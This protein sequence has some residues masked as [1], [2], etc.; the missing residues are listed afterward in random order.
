LFI[1]YLSVLKRR[2][3]LAKWA[4]VK[5]RYPGL[6]RKLTAEELAEHHSSEEL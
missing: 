6:I 3:A 4:D 1:D 2:S 5:D